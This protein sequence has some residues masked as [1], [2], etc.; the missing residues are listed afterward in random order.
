MRFKCEIWTRHSLYF[1]N[2]N[3]GISD[4]DLTL[5]VSDDDFYPE[6]LI[7]I[8][9]FMKKIKK[10]LPVIGEA[11][12]YT[13]GLIDEYSM[14][15]NYFELS[16]DPILKK[17]CRKKENRNFQT[18]GLVFFLRGLYSDIEKIKEFNKL[19]LKK[20]K[21]FEKLIKTKIPKGFLDINDTNFNADLLVTQF[22]K[23][24]NDK[25]HVDL[26]ELNSIFSN[27]NEIYVLSDSELFRKLFPHRWLYTDKETYFKYSFKE[28]KKLYQ[29]DTEEEKKIIYQQIAWEFSGVLSQVGSVSNIEDIVFHMSKLVEILDEISINSSNNELFSDLKKSMLGFILLIAPWIDSDSVIN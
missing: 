1:N 27:K 9:Q 15:F 12:I 29:S 5:I 20:W 19:R 26:D 28:D 2:I 11:N 25:I 14:Y 13:N 6:K 10:I 7:E 4:I 21:F 16:R 17:R 24:F 18:E 3:P 8:H 22:H 23:A